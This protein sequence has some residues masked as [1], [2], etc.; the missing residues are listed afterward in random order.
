MKK[1]ILYFAFFMLVPFASF[2]ANPNMLMGSPEDIASVAKRYGNVKE[3]T[4]D[5]GDP[6]LNI[7]GKNVSFSVYFYDCNNGER[8]QDIQFW[9][10]WAN[11]GITLEELNIWNSENRFGRAYLDGDED[12]NL[13]MDVSIKYGMT[14]KALR[15]WFSIWMD[16]VKTFEKKM[17]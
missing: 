10:Y 16:V 14:K 5:Y 11:P 17:L 2:A 3:T 15:E 8:C 1:I 12:V 4:D 7:T 6:L 13:E 9:T